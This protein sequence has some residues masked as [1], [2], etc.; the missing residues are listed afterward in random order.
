M[1]IIDGRQ[2]DVNV[3]SYANLEE[4]LQNTVEAD[5]FKDRVVTDVLLNGEAFSEIY[6]HQ[7]ED[8]E[9][10]EVDR[11]EIVSV[12]SVEMA[13]D[14][15][16][17][18]YKVIT[19]MENGGRHVADLFRQ[20]DDAEALETYQ[21]LLDVMRD[22][23]GMITLL[24]QQY[25]ASGSLG[26]ETAGKELTELFSEMIEVQENEDWILLADLLEYEFLPA[27]GK[28]K[29]IIADLR[30]QIRNERS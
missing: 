23:L 24:R 29:K 9:I 6:P 17:E 25:A 22:F 26:I 15:T 30:A 5:Y 16:R 4:V 28:W 7:A 3:K 18:L 1:L 13:V 8:I 19:L 12:P 21:D 11:V 27:V 2:A 14:I 10:E 20:A